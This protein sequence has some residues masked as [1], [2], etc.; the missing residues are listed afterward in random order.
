MADPWQRRLAEALGFLRRRLAGDYAVDDFG[1]DPEFNAAVL[2]PLARALY[3]QWFRIEVRGI[4]NVPADGGALIVANHAG[5]LPIDALMV[6]VAMLDH[7]PAQ[8]NLRALGADL[9]YDLPVLGHVARKSGHTL[10][11]RTD[12]ERLLSSGHLVGVWPEGFKGIG[13]PYTQRYKLQRFGR[14]GF[15]ASALRTSAPVVPCSIVGSEEIYPMIGNL[16]M[17]ARLLGL[18][19]FPLTPTFPWLG[20]LGVLPLPSKWIIDFGTPLRTDPYPPRAAD[21]PGLVFELTDQVRETIQDR[22]HEL[23]RDRGCPF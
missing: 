18:P 15:M 20:A 6:Q 3:Y 2:M 11:C 10:A 13:K 16:E 21:D 14:G 4:A 1:Y 5:T 7:H 23:L 19:Y 12:A 22:L 17:L 9:V 8:R